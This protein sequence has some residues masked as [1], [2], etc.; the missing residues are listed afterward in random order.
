MNE[1]KQIFQYAI[2]Q[3]NEKL[4]NEEEFQLEGQVAEIEY[5]NEVTVSR[6]LCG[7]LE[8]CYNFP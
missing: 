2:E 3:A 7:L 8:V 1:N 6:G 5:G 4:L